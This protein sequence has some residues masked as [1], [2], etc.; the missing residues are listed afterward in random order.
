MVTITGAGGAAPEGESRICTG[1][2]V[3]TITVSTPFSA[4]VDIGDTYTVDF[5]TLVDRGASAQDARLTWGVN[6]DITLVYSEPVH[7]ATTSSALSGEGGYN[8]ADSDM[9]AEWYGTGGNIVNLPLFE[10][11]DGI[12]SDTGIPTQTLYIFF[13]M[14]LCF[15]F[16]IAGFLM[17]NSVMISIIG[18]G[19]GLGI[20]SAMTIVPMWIL[21]VFL[22]MSLGI[23]YLKGRSGI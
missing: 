1:S 20:G 12:S 21:F 15:A 14:S 9:P 2:T 8:V 19:I 18:I 4:N 23:L 6:E 5:A 3:G 10:M 22:V 13:I 7:S 17:F 16:C 11:F